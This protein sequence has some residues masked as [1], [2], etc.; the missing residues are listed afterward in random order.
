MSAPATPATPSRRRFPT[1]KRSPAA[2]EGKPAGRETEAKPPREPRRPFDYAPDAR[3]E[4][5]GALAT[6]LPT[7]PLWM[8][9]SIAGVL[10]VTGA[11]VAIGFLPHLL[12]AVGRG[13]GPRFA[14]TVAALRACLDLRSGGLAAALS[15]LFLLAAAAVAIAVR[16][17]R[18]HRRDGRQGRARAW[19]S[20]ALIL[21]TAAIA[22]RVPLGRLFAALVTDSSGRAF[23]PEG[24]GWWVAAAGVT[25]VTVALWAVLPL[26]Q[27][28]FPGLWLAA[29]LAGW[30][31]AASAPWL[32]G[33]E[34][35]T[36][37]GIDTALVTPAAWLV[38]AAGMLVATLVA[39]RGVIRE[40]RG[41]IQAAP[42]TAHATR[43]AA[44]PVAK[45]AAETLRGPEA[46]AAEPVFE[47]IET[48]ADAT[49]A[50]ERSDGGYTDGSDL[51]DDYASRPLSK[52]ER[53]RL[54]KLAK[55][56]QAA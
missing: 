24:T 40:V 34:Q 47:P 4:R 52:A 46:P 48:E 41:E 16:G 9:L 12:D 8:A 43:A 10:A 53:K 5:Q 18:R 32:A 21:V 7:R 22:G 49:P 19:G 33:M 45:P 1:W 56:G 42:A 17:M 55:S 3:P 30:G 6:R 51:E 15:E 44:K 13:A 29:G 39:A 27:R 26:H 50:A 14:G 20:L 11:T 2:A 37:R 23:G 31:V 35:V 54:R 28:L 25:S 36:A 38:G